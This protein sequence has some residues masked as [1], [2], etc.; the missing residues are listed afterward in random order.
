[1][2]VFLNAVLLLVFTQTVI[3]PVAAEDLVTRPATAAPVPAARELASELPKKNDINIDITKVCVVPGYPDAARRFGMQGKTILKLKIDET[4][5]I[6]AFEL[7][8]SSGWKMLDLTVMR[9]IVGC[10]A[11]PAGSWIPSERDVAYWWQFDKGYT[12][13]AVIDQKSCAASE[14][15]RVADDKDKEL[16]IVVGIYT[17]ATGKVIDA[18]VQ[19]GSGD[20]A[21]DQE[22]LRIAKSCDYAPAERSGKRIGNAGSIRFV[23]NTSQR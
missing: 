17:D 6:N 4:G 15:L 5:K 12:S 9:A 3:L 1:M 13:P 2:R 21:Q 23:A 18:K 16:G 19:W 14:Q 22:S 8:R 10:Q 11:I 7:A 20:E